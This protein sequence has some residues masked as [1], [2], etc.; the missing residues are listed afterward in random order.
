MLTELAFTEEFLGSHVLKVPAQPATGS[1]EGGTPREQRSKAK[2]FSTING[3]SVVIKESS[4][5]SNKGES[6]WGGKSQDR[7]DG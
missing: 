5:Y 2:Q 6:Q 1:G 7:A 3:R 4:V